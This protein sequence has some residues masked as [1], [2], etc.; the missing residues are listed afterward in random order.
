VP[1]CVFISYA[2]ED[3]KIADA[4][5]TAMHRSRIA[6]AFIDKVAL[7]PGDSLAG[8]IGDALASSPTLAAFT[9]D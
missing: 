6:F 5:F 7:G 1:S 9:D 2:H 3:A 8:K 4:V